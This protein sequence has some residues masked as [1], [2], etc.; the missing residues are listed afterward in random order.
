MSTEQLAIELTPDTVDNITD[1]ELISLLV[2][3]GYQEATK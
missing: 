1:S 2:E 3:F